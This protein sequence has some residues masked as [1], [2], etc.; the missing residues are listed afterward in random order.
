MQEPED[1]AH[2]VYQQ[3]LTALEN[4]Y[5]RD[6]FN[7]ETI[8]AEYEA[9]TVYQGHGMDGRNLYKEAEIEGQIDAYQIFI[10]RRLQ[11]DDID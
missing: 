6:D 3:T 11:N 4:R 2:E 5:L 1:Y 7:L 10:H 9:L 8:Q